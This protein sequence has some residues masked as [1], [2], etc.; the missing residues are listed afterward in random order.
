MHVLLKSNQ[1]IL[2]IDNRELEALWGLGYTETDR[3]KASDDMGGYYVAY[4]TNACEGEGK[5]KKY[6]K[7]SRLAMYSKG[8]KFYRCSRG[9][10]KPVVVDEAYDTLLASGYK[11]TYASAFDIVKDGVKLNTVQKEVMKR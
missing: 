7:G 9:I 4:F 2:F 11:T 8:F 5:S 6:V 1:E 3:L 10:A